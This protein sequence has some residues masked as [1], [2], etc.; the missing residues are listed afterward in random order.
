MSEEIFNTE[1]SS[2]R[3]LAGRWIFLLVAVL[4]V[5]GG[6][7]FLNRVPGQSRL[8]QLEPAPIKGHP[9]PEISLVSTGGEP[10]SL[11]DFKGKPVVINFWATW[12][13]PCRAETPD[14]QEV[15]RELG[16]EMVI[17]G[18]NVTQQ[19]QGDIEAFLQEFGVTYPVGLDVDGE[20]FRA[21]SVLGL[22]TTVF[23]DRNG[24]INEVFTGPVTKAYVASK[25]GDL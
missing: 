20:A 19:D 4:V 23:V 15:H 11:S 10:L 6:L 5:G 17:F 21:Y 2:N 9:A 3:S 16:D 7:I 8:A 12:C 14:L 13:A 18:V 24:I 25:L 1:N 22:P